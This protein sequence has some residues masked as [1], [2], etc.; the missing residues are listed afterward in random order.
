M[1]K[2][3]TK[4]NRNSRG[5]SQDISFEYPI[6]EKIT[7]DK[8]NLHIQLDKFKKAV[9][10]S[11]NLDSSFNFLVTLL[12]VWVPI[13]TSDFKTTLGYDPSSIKGG[14]FGFVV[15]VTFYL[16]Y[17]FVCKP[18]WFLFLSN[19]KVSQDPEKMA[20]IILDKCNKK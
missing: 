16:I 1:A 19:S 6:S 20:Q 10:D 18:I 5:S 12:A 3:D 4:T 2:I 15:F 14:Y 8:T 17:K 9:S 13:F 11:F 7:I